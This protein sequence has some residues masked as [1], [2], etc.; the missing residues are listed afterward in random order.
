[1]R[2]WSILGELINEL[3]RCRYTFFQDC[4]RIRKKINCSK[5]EIFDYWSKQICII[6][7]KNISSHIPCTPPL[8]VIV[9]FTKQ[10]FFKKKNFLL[11]LFLL[12]LLLLFL[13]TVPVPAEHQNS[14]KTR[15]TLKFRMRNKPGMYRLG[16]G[17]SKSQ[18]PDD[19]REMIFSADSVK[20]VL[21][22]KDQTKDKHETP[23][24]SRTCERSSRRTNKLVMTYV[25]ARMPCKNQVYL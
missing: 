5:F 22:Q 24:R 4:K 16:P 2:F 6:V 19:W 15:Y 20:G 10:Y 9:S 1:M 13:L 7:I 18:L 11:L 14:V 25:K 12:L 17:P 3:S 8:A 21:G 23:P